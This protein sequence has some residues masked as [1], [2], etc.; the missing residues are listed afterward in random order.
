MLD[1]MRRI[2]RPLKYLNTLDFLAPLVL[3]LYLVPVLWLAGTS[4]LN[5]IENT[6]TWFGNTT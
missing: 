1:L 2:N 4:K 3:R 5:N 6:V